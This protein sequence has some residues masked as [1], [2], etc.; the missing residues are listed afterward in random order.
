MLKF[1]KDFINNLKIFDTLKIQ[2][3]IAINFFHSKETDE[4]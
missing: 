2:S 4:H 3:T 1:L